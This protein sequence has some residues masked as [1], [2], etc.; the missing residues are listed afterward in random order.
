MSEIGMFRQ[1]AFPAVFA[2]NSR[3]ARIWKEVADGRRYGDTPRE[4]V[5]RAHG[6]LSNKSS[7]VS[8]SARLRFGL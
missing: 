4:P 8:K 6:A 1:V 7:F 5:P 2:L 3:M